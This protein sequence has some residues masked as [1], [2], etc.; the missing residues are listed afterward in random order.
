MTL[1]EPPFDP[2]TF[3]WPSDWQA[4]PPG[5]EEESA[6]ALGYLETFQT[7]E[8]PATN[9]VDELRREM[10]DEHRLFR[11]NFVPIACSTVDPDDVLFYTD[12]P[13][14]PFAFVHL[15][16]HT[17]RSAAFPYC[18]TFRTIDE[19]FAACSEGV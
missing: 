19:F 12:D 9:F 3:H 18:R 14:E 11:R 16:W 15:T 6:D 5:F 13:N 7:D 10:C 4:I 17:E 1:I 8:I 2:A